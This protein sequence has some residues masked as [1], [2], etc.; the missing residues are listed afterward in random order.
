MESQFHAMA[1]AAPDKA[2]TDGSPTSPPR[3]RILLV[4]RSGALAAELMTTVLNVAQR[5]GL[6][7][8]CLY[9]DALSPKTDP[10]ACRPT[11]AVRARIN[12]AL[13]AD[14]ARRRGVHAQAAITSGKVAQAVADLVAASRGTEFVV[15]EPGI[16]TRELKSLLSV[17]VF[18]TVVAAG[19]PGWSS[20]SSAGWFAQQPD[21]GRAGLEFF[22]AHS[23]RGGEQMAEGVSR[24]KTVQKTFVFGAAAAAIYAAVFYFTD[25]LMSFATRGKFYALVPVGTVFLFSYIH[26]N[27]T[28]YFWSA[29][30]IEAS[31]RTGV[32]PTVKAVKPVKRKDTRPRARLSV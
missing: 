8:V 16:A 2:G 1:A 10:A 4:S 17:P 23:H 6:D 26:G 19:K 25:P 24:K 31:K 30:G 5:L 13:L 28:S 29:L 11:F 21:T 15:L 27:F 7:L 14:Q 32:K 12:A 9:I 18:A 22:N 20:L 3:K